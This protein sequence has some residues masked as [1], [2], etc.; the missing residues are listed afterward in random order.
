[1]TPR[2]ARKIRIFFTAHSFRLRRS[3][4]IVRRI[5]VLTG[6]GRYLISALG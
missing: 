4:S 6:S 3:L 5:T 1:M 2:I